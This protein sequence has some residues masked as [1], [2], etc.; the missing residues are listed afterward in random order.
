MVSSFWWGHADKLGL[1]GLAPA[2]IKTIEQALESARVLDANEMYKEASRTKGLI[3][4]S[5]LRREPGATWFFG[6]TVLRCQASN[7]E[8]GAEPGLR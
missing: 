6:S 7:A 3:I 1:K 8:F 2:R 5:L 4:D